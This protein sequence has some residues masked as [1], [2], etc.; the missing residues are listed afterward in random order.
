MKQG[1]P[2]LNGQQPDVPEARL[3]IGFKG[4]KQPGG[5][6]EY[7]GF[8]SEGAPFPL[9]LLVNMLQVALAHYTQMQVQVMHEAM[10]RQQTQGIVLPDGSPPPRF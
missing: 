1:Q 7:Y 5:M 6:P 4:G 10:A 2:A 8:R 9:P 3:V